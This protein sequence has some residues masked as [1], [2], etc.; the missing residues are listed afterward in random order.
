MLQFCLETFRDVPAP[1]YLDSWLTF[2]LFLTIALSNGILLL[3]VGYKF[4]QIIQLSGYNLKGMR[5]WL[6]ETKFRYWGNLVMLSFLSTACL[7]MTNV[8][9]EGFFRYKI[10]T[11]I[12]LIFYLVF[13]IIFIRNLYNAPQKTPLKY[14]QR[15]TRM[16]V[17]YFVLVSVITFFLMTLTFSNVLLGL[18][19]IFVPLIV[20]LAF[21]ITAPFEIMINRHFV[22]KA[23]KIISTRKNKLITIG[24]TGSFGKTTVKNMLTT[25]LSKKYKVCATPYSFNTPLGLSKTIIEYLSENHEIFITEMGAKCTGDIAY[26]TQMVHPSIGVITGIGNQHLSTFGTLENL[27]NTKFELIAN[28]ERDGVAYFNGDSKG[29]I[30]LFE[31][32]T[33]QRKFLTSLGDEKGKFRV[34]NVKVDG[35]GSTFDLVLDGG[36]PLRCATSLLGRH[37]ISNILLCAT[38]AFNLGL[39]RE[40]IRSG[41]ES[42]SPS[43]H[44]LAI[45]PSANS[46]IVLDDAY[47]G[48]VEGSRA[49]LDVLALFAGKK[50][51]VTPGLVELGRESSAANEEF[52]RNMAKV[53][54]GVFLVGIVNS[55]ALTRGLIAGG[56]DEKKIFRVGSLAQAT[57]MLGNVA[58]PGDVVLFENDLPDNYT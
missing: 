22:N 46:L 25:L 7:L 4:L 27:K 32:A 12:G 18:T 36:K 15:M 31:R 35:K 45:V 29:A 6:V 23:K 55:E 14:T 3:F 52:G 19:P 24:I 49:A 9:L 42:L 28:L 37:N 48:S 41:I 38:I 8:L 16:S 57:S 21:L 43:S 34:E 50:Y 2:W 17:V 40:E 10:M 30:E 5:A 20:V 51:V 44:R 1:L 53:A 39:S 26:L 56:F 13:C 54:D 47:N 58:V 33:L 11:Y